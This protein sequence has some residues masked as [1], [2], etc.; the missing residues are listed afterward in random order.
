[1]QYRILGASDL[2]LSVIGLGTWA[3]GG[4]GWRFSWGPQVDEQSIKTIHHALD[5]GINWVDT[6]PIYGLGHA[7]EVVGKA[8]AGLGEKPII[9]TKCSRKSTPDGQL[10]SD[11]KKASILQEAEDSL[12][13]LRC[14]VIDLYQIHWP[15]PATDLEEGWEAIAQLINDGKIRYG[16]VSNFAIEH[17]QRCH[18]LYPITSLQP[19]YSMLV[20]HIEDGIIDYC[21][22]NNI[23]LLAYSPMYKGLLTGAF[24]KQRLANLPATD[25]RREDLHFQEPELSANLQLVER[26]GE[27]AKARAIT[28]AQ[29]CIAWTLR[30]PQMTAAIVGGRRPQQVDETAAA[31]DVVLSEAEIAEIEELLQQRQ[32]RLRS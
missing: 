13:R 1:M 18:A 28:V 9:A 22:K 7:E 30:H 6:A 15:K 10:Y 29:L 14:E 5:L 20:R 19:P 23:G 27:I 8:L 31:G 16:G 21:D 17:M 11:L 32:A 3:M 2:K 24:N 25:H 4:E 12:R 26:L